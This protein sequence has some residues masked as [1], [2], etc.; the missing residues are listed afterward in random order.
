MICSLFASGQEKHPCSRERTVR[1]FSL[2][3]DF[4]ELLSDIEDLIVVV[5]LLTPGI[6]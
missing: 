4:A 2:A 1:F 6:A 5:L 3:F